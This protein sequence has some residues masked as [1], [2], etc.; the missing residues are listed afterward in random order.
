[1]I[2]AP[3]GQPIGQ[4]FRVVLDFT[5]QEGKLAIAAE[6]VPLPVILEMLLGAVKALFANLA[7]Q[8]ERRPDISVPTFVPPRGVGNQ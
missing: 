3:N 8:V 2:V 5:P 4:T 6:G 7:Q 1:M